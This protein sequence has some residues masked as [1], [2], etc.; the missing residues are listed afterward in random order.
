[1]PFRFTTTLLATLSLSGAA[2]SSLSTLV[3][4]NILISAVHFD[5]FS[6]SR[7]DA[8]ILAK[9]TMSSIASR[10]SSLSSQSA[11]SFLPPKPTYNSPKLVQDP[12]LAPVHP[13]HLGTVPHPFA[14]SS[15][16]TSRRAPR[17]PEQFGD[18]SQTFSKAHPHS[19]LRSTSE[20]GAMYHSHDLEHF[21]V[22][23]APSAEPDDFSASIKQRQRSNTV[24]SH[25][26]VCSGFD[27]VDE[28]LAS[29]NRFKSQFDDSD[30]EEKVEFAN[31]S[32][33]GVSTRARLAAIGTASRL[34]KP[35]RHSRASS[36]GLTLN[37]QLEKS[38]ADQRKP[39]SFRPSTSEAL[40][41]L[42][43]QAVFGHRP[44]PSELSVV[45][46]SSKPRTVEAADR[47]LILALQ[48]RT[49][50]TRSKP[51]DKNKAAFK[52]AEQHRCSHVVL[53]SANVLLN[54]TET[55]ANW[56]DPPPYCSPT[57]AEMGRG[58]MLRKSQSLSTLRFDVS[59]RPVNTYISP[60][61]SPKTLA[62]KA[63]AIASQHTNQSAWDAMLS[64][65]P[66]T[67]SDY[68]SGDGYANVTQS[69]ARS[70]PTK[71]AKT[72]RL[73]PQK[74]PPMTRLPLPPLPP[75]DTRVRV[76]S[77]AQPKSSKPSFES[78]LSS[79][80]SHGSTRSST[81]STVAP[82]A[83]KDRHTWSHA[84]T[85][86]PDS[87]VVLDIGGTKFVTLVST[88]EGANRDEPRLL[89]LLQS[90]AHGVACNDSVLGC[91]LTRGQHTSSRSR[92]RSNSESSQGSRR[93]CSRAETTASSSS[94]LDGMRESKCST[95]TSCS[96]SF[97][98]SWSNNVVT[99]CNT[100]ME[101]A[102][103]K[104]YDALADAD[105]VSGRV[106]ASPCIFLDRN[107]DLYRD[108]LDILRYRK[109]PYRLQASSVAATRSTSP[110]NPTDPTLTAL[111]I[112]LRCRL[113][114][115]MHEASWLGYLSIV[116]MCHAE[117]AV[118]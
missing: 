110:D 107:A 86:Q 83:L 71:H 22:S 69:T 80:S 43:R 1:M 3:L 7:L 79:P 76:Q 26:T 36:S 68:A 78:E 20:F 75:K 62:P 97:D 81:Q 30:D 77:R 33:A 96:G 31:L 2:V 44:T 113:H 115:L 85:W 101:P 88:L 112:Q 6:R 108:L 70:C 104:S 50:K 27:A 29:P 58:Q 38:E 91:L 103:E 5:C 82:S 93:S 92:E 98:L 111:H 52:Q 28:T 49:C 8:V 109:L 25:L 15:Y 114:E 47:D 35:K 41:P 4:S 17:K 60:S 14:S 13:E 45:S 84:S 106:R 64:S 61:I 53:E 67:V 11:N 24:G 9:D 102:Q 73:P 117:I 21:A 12:I 94:A 72:Q 54:H 105:H 89:A 39:C 51:A 63:A 66:S 23:D 40:S 74:P 37:M 56:M 65:P 90:S 57:E 19:H 95:R 46:S 18:Q 16:V 100:D 116:D 48:G 118:V 87:Q 59:R 99:G 55:G 32:F 34:F 42:P 10:F